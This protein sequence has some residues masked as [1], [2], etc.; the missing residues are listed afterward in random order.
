MRECAAA[1][2]CAACCILL[3][4]IVFAGQASAANLVGGGDSSATYRI[5]A[6]EGAILSETLYVGEASTLEVY[7]DGPESIL[8]LRFFGAVS[9]PAFVLASGE[10]TVIRFF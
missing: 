1:F 4:E 9:E 8:D 7:G 2:G 6:A 3:L 5:P 10:S